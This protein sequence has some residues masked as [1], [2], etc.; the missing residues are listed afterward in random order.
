MHFLRVLVASTAVALAAILTATSAHRLLADTVSPAEEADP[1]EVAI[2]E[3]LFLGQATVKTHV[4]R[5][6]A[7]IGTQSRARAVRYAISN[8]LAKPGSGDG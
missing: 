4:N 2:G 1:A 7:K 8:G 3:R 5:I 6:F